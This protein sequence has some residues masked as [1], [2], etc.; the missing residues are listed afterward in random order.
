MCPIFDIA[1][2]NEEHYNDNSAEIT[3]TRSITE[4]LIARLS[5]AQRDSEHQIDRLSGGCSNKKHERIFFV[6]QAQSNEGHQNDTRIKSRATG[7]I[8]G[9]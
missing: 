8:R 1:P 7:R 5:Q 4:N 3:A 9:T 2:S 6:T